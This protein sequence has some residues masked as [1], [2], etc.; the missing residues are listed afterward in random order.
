M[1]AVCKLS[2]CYFSAASSRPAGHGDVG[3]VCHGRRA[4]DGEWRGLW[5]NSVG[6]DGFS[7]WAQ[8]DDTKQFRHMISFFFSKD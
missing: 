4:L 5:L 2:W 1:R 3:W 7:R 8:A 6:D